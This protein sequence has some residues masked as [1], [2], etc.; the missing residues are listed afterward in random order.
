MGEAMRLYLLT[1]ACLSI[2]LRPLIVGSEPL[3]HAGM[4]ALKQRSGLAARVVMDLD[5]F[6]RDA[7]DSRYTPNNR[8]QLLLGHLS[9]ARAAVAAN[10]S[11]GEG[12]GSSLDKSGVGIL[13][14]MISNLLEQTESDVSQSFTCNNSP[15][16]KAPRLCVEDSEKLSA[17]VKK[18]DRFKKLLLSK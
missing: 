1:V 3:V 4:D 7:R 8:M 15:D 2:L 16:P 13:A 5:E 6:N 12:E 17:V 18:V 14:G 11:S 9:R 10:L